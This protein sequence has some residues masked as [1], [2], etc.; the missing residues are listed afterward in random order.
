[1]NGLDLTS[2]ALR[3]VG[4]P[5]T[6]ADPVVSTRVGVVQGAEH[7]WRFYERGSRYVSRK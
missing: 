5:G 1:M 2:G 6:V 7:P 3:I 4:E